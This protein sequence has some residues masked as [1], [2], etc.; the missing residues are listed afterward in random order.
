M[1]NITPLIVIRLFSNIFTSL[2]LDL[3]L[4]DDQNE[5]HEQLTLKY[6]NIHYRYIVKYI[7]LHTYR[8]QVIVLDSYSTIH[9]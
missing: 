7:I 5:L 2:L 4:A 8:H 1:K 6:V 3:L 9:R